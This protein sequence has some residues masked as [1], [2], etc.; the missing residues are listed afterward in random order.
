MTTMI[1]SMAAAVIPRQGAFA[2]GFVAGVAHV[3]T[4]ITCFVSM[5]VIEGLFAAL[6][7]RSSV[8]APGIV[9]VID[10]AKEAAGAT[11]PWA[12]SEED[13]SIK[14][15]GP[16]VP[17]GSAVVRG[18][19]EVAVRANGGRP[20]VHSDGNLCRGP[21]CAAKKR[22]CKSREDKESKMGHGF[23]SNQLE[24]QSAPRVV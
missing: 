6:G 12:R 22:E 11:E 5:E 23:S 17:V 7:Q 2:A 20:D 9:A 24:R 21:G 14:P 18:I 10:M 13:S 15:V 8:T 3:A 19:V 4:A 1:V 16:V